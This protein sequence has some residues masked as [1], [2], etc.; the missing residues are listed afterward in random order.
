MSRFDDGGIVGSPR[1]QKT[2]RGDAGLLLETVT[3][4]TSTENLRSRIIEPL[5]LTSTYF[6]P[7]AAS[8]PIDGF[9]PS[10]PE[11]DTKSVSYV[12]LETA[13]GTAGALVS[14]AQD[15]STFIRA[16]AHGKLL[17]PDIYAEMTRSL[18]LAGSTLGVFPADPATATGISN[19]GSIPGF[20]ALM[21]YHPTTQNLFVLLLN[22]DSRTPEQLA[23]QLLKIVQ[24]G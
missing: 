6:A 24:L 12:G 22:D 3:G 9:S 20:T 8:S 23:T 2:D 7:N 5:G 11:G 13:A 18:P 4:S 15:L 16:L 14:N 17:P 19:S 21:Q 10:L 1:L